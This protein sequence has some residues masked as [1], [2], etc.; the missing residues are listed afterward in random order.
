MSIHRYLLHNGQIKET[1]EASLFAGQL[2]LLAGWGVFTTLRVVDGALFAWER[3]W[4]RMSRDA[5]LLNVEMPRDPVQVQ[6]DLVH[7]VEKNEA[8]DCT[9]RLV[10]IRNGGGFWEGP[11]SGRASDTIALTA[12]SKRWGASV[13]LG[14]QPHARFAASDFTPT[15]VLS[16]AQNLRWAERAQEQGFDEVILLNEYGRVAECTSANVFA[17]FGQEV[18]T[19]PGSEGCLPGITREVLLEEVHVPGVR[20]TERELTVDELYKADEVFITSTTRGLLP[21]K[22]IEG[23]PLTGQHDVG[24]RLGRAFQSFVS[25]DIARRRSAS[26][27]LA[28]VNA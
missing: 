17:V 8:P 22:E 24:E 14:I 19:P 28:P 2:G 25:N 16:W 15:K 11:A 18:S 9:M 10:V 21:V 5:R 7:L 3:H 6:R 13:R 20:L 1:A 23:R 27:W 26:T 12:A 4:A